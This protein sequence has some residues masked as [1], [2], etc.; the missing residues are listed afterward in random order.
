[1]STSAPLA[2]ARGS[3]AARSVVVIG[4]VLQS[5]A[6]TEKIGLIDP[7][8]SAGTVVGTSG[9]PTPAVPHRATEDHDPETGLA[10]FELEFPRLPV[11]PGREVG[12]G[13]EFLVRPDSAGAS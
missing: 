9:G 5:S 13:D 7:A 3:A 1:M 2:P 12:R 8:A 4:T 10:R 6:L 11:D